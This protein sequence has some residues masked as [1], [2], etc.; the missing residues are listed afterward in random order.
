MHARPDGALPPTPR[1]TK[2]DE[3]AARPGQRR[4]HVHPSPRT[5]SGTPGR[6]RPARRA[7]SG[8]RS[9]DRAAAG[10][11][12]RGPRHPPNAVAAGDTGLGEATAPTGRGAVGADGQRRRRTHRLG[13]AVGR[14]GAAA[15]PRR[16]RTARDPRPDPSHGLL[17]RR[18]QPG[19][20]ARRRARPR[21][22]Q[23]PGGAGPARR[24]PRR[25]TRP[26]QPGVGATRPGAGT[27]ARMVDRYLDRP[28]PP[29]GT[30]LSRLSQPGSRRRGRR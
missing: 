26:A 25:R 15:S 13:A 14:D 6:R 24:V 30:A 28:I 16:A 3:W 7:R 5:R 17:R 29:R 18:P 8:G 10:R 19:E 2:D 11:A 12:R 1:W 23:R 20:S 21:A 4:P 9:A 22:R 27:H